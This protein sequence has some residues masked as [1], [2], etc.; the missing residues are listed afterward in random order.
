M[1]TT[2]REDLRKSPEWKLSWDELERAGIWDLPSEETQRLPIYVEESSGSMVTV[3]LWDGHAYRAWSFL[4]SD[5]ATAGWSGNGRD[6]ADALWRA[7][8]VIDSH[9]H[10]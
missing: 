4:S 1:V 2:C 7:T 8:R 6:R 9:A 10:R 3:E 5:E